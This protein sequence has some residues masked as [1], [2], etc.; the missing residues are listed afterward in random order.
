MHAK[1]TASTPEKLAVNL[2]TSLFTHDEIAHSVGEKVFRA[3]KKAEIE[4]MYSKDV[5]EEIE[6]SL[7]SQMFSITHSLDFETE[8]LEEYKKS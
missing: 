1:N 4:E 6:T 7:H 5:Y 3:K 8:Q 2:L